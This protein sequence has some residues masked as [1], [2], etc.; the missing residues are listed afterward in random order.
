MKEHCP[1]CNSTNV[2]LGTERCS[3]YEEQGLCYDCGVGLIKGTGNK[4]WETDPDINQAIL[5]R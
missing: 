3:S 2:D 1:K 4:E 5:G